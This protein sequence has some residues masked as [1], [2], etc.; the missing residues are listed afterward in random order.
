M[1]QLG[2]FNLHP[3]LL[4]KYRGCFSAPWAII[5]G[6]S[7]S[8]ITYH[9]MNGKFDDDNII[10]QETIDISDE[11]TGYSLFQKLLHLGVSRFEK[12]FDLVVR[13]KYKGSPQIGE[14]SYFPRKVPYDGYIDHQ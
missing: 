14:P 4:P 7:K 13:E 5:N 2:G 1:S 11:E 12:S 3:S 9:H 8:G 6:E 10:L